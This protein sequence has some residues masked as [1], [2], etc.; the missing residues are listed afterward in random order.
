MVKLSRD[1]IYII[2][3]NSNWSAQGVQ[4][5]LKE[6]LY[7]SPTSWQQ[8]LR[9]FFLSLGIGFATFGVLFFFAYNWADLHKFV[10]LGLMEGLIIITTFVV[11]FTKFNDLI[12][13]LALTSASI[14]VG[15]L[16]AVFGQIYQ[17]G[18]NAY[19]FFLG[20]TLFIS[21]WVLI[22]NFAPLWL[23]Y[24]TLINT[25]L[26]LYSQQVAQD[27]SGVFISTLLLLVNSLFFIFFIVGFKKITKISFPKWFFYTI[28]LAAIFSATIGIVVGIF[29][30]FDISFWTLFVLTSI[31]YASAVWYSL[32]IKTT[33]YLAIIAFSLVVIITSFLIKIFKSD[34][35]YLIVTLF[36]IGSI[37][38]SIKLLLDLQKKWTNG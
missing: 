29:S 1:D 37:T 27:W 22:S 34:A 11:L 26:I 38:F 8:F 14:L 9:L 33:F 17:T 24:L 13:N 21:L 10:K 23:I 30:K 28:A 12:K 16:F 36:I 6:K 18:A 19:D 35:S 4:S 5:I 25:T 7:S 2:S 3:Q 15:V 20:W 32:Q 31:L